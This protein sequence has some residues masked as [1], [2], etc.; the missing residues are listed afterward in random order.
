MTFVNEYIPEE[1]RKK[2]NITDQNHF[3]LTGVSDWT[4]DR[5]QEIFLLRRTG[6]TPESPPGQNHWAFF[7]HGHLLDVLLLTIATSGDDR[8]GHG[9]AHKKVLRI[10]GMTP[11]LEAKRSKIIN[12]LREAL[13]TNRGLGVFSDYKSYELILDAE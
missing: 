13:T 8:I 7:W 10:S 12:D 6:R 5:E 9:F 4:I 11:E 1:D 2:Y 3:Y